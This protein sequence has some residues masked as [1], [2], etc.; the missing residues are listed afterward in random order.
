VNWRI[1]ACPFSNR[2]ASSCAGSFDGLLM[3]P[4][5]CRAV[6]PRQ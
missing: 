6:T 2:R 5:S 4:P 3:V 1:I